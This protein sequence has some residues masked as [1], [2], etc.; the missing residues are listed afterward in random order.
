MPQEGE[1]P[2]AE[3]GGIFSYS[4]GFHGYH[5]M[6]GKGAGNPCYSQTKGGSLFSSLGLCDWHRGW[7]GEGVRGWWGEGVGRVFFPLV[8]EWSS[9]CLKGFCPAAPLLIF[10]KS[11]LSLGPVFIVI[12]IEV[13]WLPSLVWNIWGSKE[14][15]SKLTVMLDVQIPGRSA[16]SL[17]F[18]VFSIFALYTMSRVFCC[19]WWKA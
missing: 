7:E 14:Q 6:G 18:R 16:F 12:S 9:Y 5:P 3:Q 17:S 4:L 2:S 11:R 19:T 15:L 13:S 1:A 8:F 10:A